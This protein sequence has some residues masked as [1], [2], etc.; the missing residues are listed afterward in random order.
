MLDAPLS[1]HVWTMFEE[2]EDGVGWIVFHQCLLS[3]NYHV[4]KQNNHP[5]QTVRG[6]LQELRWEWLQHAS[7]QCGQAIL[8]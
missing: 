8:A 1:A 4:H 2:E 5:P 6:D 7:Q 3:Y